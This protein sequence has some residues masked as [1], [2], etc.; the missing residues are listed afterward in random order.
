MLNYVVLIV[1]VAP[2]MSKAFQLFEVLNDRGKSLEALD[3]IKNLFLKK[4]DRD[5]TGSGN[6]NKFIENWNGFKKN[7]ALGTKKIS[8]SIFLRHYIIGMEGKNLK[9]DKL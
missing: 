9:K 5:N 8:G 2:S 1:T 3:L 6:S 4:I 7:L